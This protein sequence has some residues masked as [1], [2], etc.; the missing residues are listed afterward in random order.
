MAK[1]PDGYFGFTVTNETK[2]K[3]VF[4]PAMFNVQA[5]GRTDT[6]SVVVMISPGINNFAPAEAKNY[7]IPYYVT[8][9]GRTAYLTAS[10][11]SPEGILY[12]SETISVRL[13]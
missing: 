12:D 6:R 13:R 5:T 3:S 4:V 7:R 8:G 10:V 1:K 2:R 9:G 11:S